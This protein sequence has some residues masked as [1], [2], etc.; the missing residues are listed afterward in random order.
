[1]AKPGN[2]LTLHAL[3]LRSLEFLAELG[4]G[5]WNEFHFEQTEQAKAAK[6]TIKALCDLWI[7]NLLSYSLVSR[8][9]ADI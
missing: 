1:M 8:F 2:G 3:G 7:R 9:H 4:C 5:P 6:M